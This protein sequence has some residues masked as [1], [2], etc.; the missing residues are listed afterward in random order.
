MAGAEDQL[1]AMNV[2]L[3]ATTAHKPN[4]Y[5]FDGPIAKLHNANCD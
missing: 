1:K 2:S 4:G 5:R 3:A